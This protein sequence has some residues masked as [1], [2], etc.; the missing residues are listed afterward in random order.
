MDAHFSFDFIKM[1]SV[2]T[3]YIA[4][5]YLGL[6]NPQR[7]RFDFGLFLKTFEESLCDPLEGIM[8]CFGSHDYL[9]LHVVR[10]VLELNPYVKICRLCQ[11]NYFLSYLQSFDF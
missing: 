4:Q 2:H 3:T 11:S 9:S 10:E 7:C 6:S 1:I 5:K 8:S